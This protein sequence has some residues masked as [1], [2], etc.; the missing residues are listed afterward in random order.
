MNLGEIFFAI[1]V[2]FL[3]KSYWSELIGAIKNR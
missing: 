3:I 2:V 1:C